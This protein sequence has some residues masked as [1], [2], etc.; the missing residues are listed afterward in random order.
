M[1][2]AILEKD[3]FGIRKNNKKVEL[4]KNVFGKK[5]GL[6]TSLFGCWHEEISR[7]FT[8]NK[9]A[10]RACLNCGA[11]KPFDSETLVTDNNFYY[12]PIVKNLTLE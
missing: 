10:Y 8:E 11:R 12:P 5:I 9:T 3:V 7:P 6:F 4:N 1:G 2:S